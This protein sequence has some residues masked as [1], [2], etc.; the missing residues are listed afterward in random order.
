MEHWYYPKRYSELRRTYRPPVGEFW[1]RRAMEGLSSCWLIFKFCSS[2]CIYVSLVICTVSFCK[3][4]LHAWHLSANRYT[5]LYWICVCCWNL[6]SQGRHFFPDFDVFQGICR[7]PGKVTAQLLEGPTE[8]PLSIR[9]GPQLKCH[10]WVTR[11]WRNSGPF[12]L[13]NCQ[14]LSYSWWQSC[15]RP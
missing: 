6:C 5:I 2:W 8:F 12:W 13:K 15:S 3:P 1:P 9:L 11:F 14:S 4:F 7:Q 10:P